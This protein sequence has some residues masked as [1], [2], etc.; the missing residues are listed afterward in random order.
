[1][2]APAITVISKP[3]IAAGVAAASFAGM[4]L[5]AKGMPAP[6]DAL[7]C[8]LCIF[9]AA[10]GSAMVNALIEE[11]TDAL[12]PRA[13]GRRRAIDRLGRQAAWTLAASL[14]LSSVAVSL[15]FLGALT[16]ALIA[17][18]AAGYALA[19]TLWLKKNS[20]YGTVP[21]AVPG[22]LPVLIGYSAATSTIGADGVILFLVMLLWQPP[23]FLAFALKYKDQYE[24]AGIPVMPVSMGKGYTRLFMFIYASAL[25]PL[26]LALWLF[27]YCGPFFAASA[28][29]LGVSYLAVTYVW[30]YRKD[31]PGR[32][33]G[34][35][36]FYM[37]GVL[38]AVT[39]DMLPRSV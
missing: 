36:I 29:L 15:I 8:L 5:G 10:S 25:P 12:M 38:G 11:E 6:A 21:G 9:A 37:L 26:T 2:D 27:G 34:A 14:V 19:Y 39:L 23:H 24:A 22:A 28:A 17:A 13:A 18:A 35:S 30:V 32:A 20:P 33:F 3:G 16:A 7:I 31:E 1:M 4:A